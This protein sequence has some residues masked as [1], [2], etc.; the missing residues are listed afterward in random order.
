[1]RLLLDTQILIWAAY[2]PDQLPDKVRSLLLDGN[3]QLLFSTVSIWEVS[4]KFQLNKPDFRVNPGMLYD[5]LLANGYSELW[6]NAL[7]AMGITRLPMLHKDPF[8]R[9]LIAQ[10]IAE[11]VTLLTCDATISRYSPDILFIPR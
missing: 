7:H 10:A 9:L 8:D 5:G 1:V 3:N 6:V 2:E 11:S 4:I